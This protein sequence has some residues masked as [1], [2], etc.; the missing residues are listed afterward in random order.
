[1]ASPAGTQPAFVWDAAADGVVHEPNVAFRISVLWQAPD[2]VGGAL[3][4]GRMAAVSPPFMAG[5]VY[6]F[7]DGFESGTSD[8]WSVAAP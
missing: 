5:E 8:A 1:M 4:R 3:Q 7:A 2:H 6:L